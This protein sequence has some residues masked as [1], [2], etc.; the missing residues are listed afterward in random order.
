MTELKKNEQIQQ[1]MLKIF[2]CSLT[3]IL[4]T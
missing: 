3:H 1:Y 2:Q 4:F